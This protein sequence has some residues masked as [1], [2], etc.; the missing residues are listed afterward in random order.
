MVLLYTNIQGTFTVQLLKGTLVSMDAEFV[1]LQ[2]E[3][4]ELKSE[5]KPVIIR[6]SHKAVARITVIRG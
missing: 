3:E 5:G 2:S 1:T 4:A 6:P